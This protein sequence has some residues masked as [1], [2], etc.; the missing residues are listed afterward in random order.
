MRFLNHIWRGTKNP[1]STFDTPRSTPGIRPPTP[2]H[3]ART[4]WLLG[5][6]HA[7]THIYHVALVPLYLPIQ[8][9]LGL[10]TVDQATL[11]QTLLMLAYFVPSYAM[12]ILA[13]RLD[14]RLLLSLGLAINGLGFVGLALAPNFLWALA[15]V[16][17]AGIGGSFYHPSATAMIARL[18]PIGTGRALGLVGI[19]AGAGFFLSP[20]YTGWRAEMSGWRAPVLELGL[21]GVA[22]AALFYLVAETQSSP[23]PPTRSVHR[24]PMFPSRALWAWFVLASVLFGLRDFAG[25]GMGSLSSLFMQKVHEFGLHETGLTLSAIFLAAVISNPFFGGLSD[26]GRIR[27]TCLVLGIAALL[28]AWFPHVPPQW[29]VPVFALYGFFFMASYP[30]IE[31]ALMESVPDAVRG[32]IYGFFITVGGL[33][34][35]LSHWQVGERVNAMGASAGQTQLYFPIYTGLALLIVISLAGLPCLHAIRKRESPQRHAT[36][37]RPA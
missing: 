31:A 33:I 36:A 30:M 6:L 28:V 11:L 9:D 10:A 34:G 1:G 8:R 24:T 16:F 18:F 2:H 13:D 19:G 4:L 25:T 21:L 17:V 7:F 29:F 22:M 37:T 14:R 27:W 5:V 3:P 12:G 26:R 20:I 32:R 35:N 23:P 15:S